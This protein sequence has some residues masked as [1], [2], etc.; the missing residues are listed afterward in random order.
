M[1][2]VLLCDDDAVMYGVLCERWG[3]KRG[4][5]SAHARTA[6]EHSRG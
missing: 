5:A 3:A 4:S 1:Y 2:P 6:A